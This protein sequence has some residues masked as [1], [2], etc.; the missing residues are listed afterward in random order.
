MLDETEGLFGPTP[1]L[2]VAADDPLLAHGLERDGKYDGYMRTLMDS[3][4]G[5]NLSRVMCRSLLSVDWRGYVY[6]CDFNQML[7]LPAGKGKLSIWDIES[8]AGFDQGKITLADHCYGCTAGSGSS[9]GGSL[10]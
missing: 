4:D 10:V 2:R 3:F 7:S 8:L 5:A 1:V 6:D 9:C